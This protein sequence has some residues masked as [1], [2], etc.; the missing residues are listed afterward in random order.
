MRRH[1]NAIAPIGLAFLAAAA[2]AGP[3]PAQERALDGTY[4]YLEAESDPIRPAIDRAVA[5]MNFIT[6]PIAR[7]RLT[8]TN[9]PYRTLTIGRAEGNIS[10][11]TDQRAPIVSP[12]DG[13]PIKWTREDGEV[14]DVTTRWVEGAL[15]QTFVAEDG[16][17]KNVYVLAAD[18]ST[19]EMR[20]T[21]TSPRL[22]EPVSYTLRYRRQS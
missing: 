9:T 11:V 3:A 20:V 5:R 2:V 7:G 12:P 21:V 19:L 10:I 6:R 22:A 15:E 4:T 17:R 13:S 14:F 18:G 8:K 1:R 16:Q